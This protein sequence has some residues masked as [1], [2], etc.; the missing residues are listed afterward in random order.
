VTLI[1]LA[2]YEDVD[3]TPRTARGIG[4]PEPLALAGDTKKGYKTSEPAD[5]LPPAGTTNITYE[6]VLLFS[7]NFLF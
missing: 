1:N 6:A 7:P 2:S 3:A 4:A 5:C